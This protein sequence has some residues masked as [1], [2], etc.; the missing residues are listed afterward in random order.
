[1]FKHQ[2]SAHCESGVTASMLS[3]NGLKLSEP[4]AFG[5]AGALAFAYI[6]L[7]NLSG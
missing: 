2:Q 3:H 6:P 4:M 1:M 7:V 5:L